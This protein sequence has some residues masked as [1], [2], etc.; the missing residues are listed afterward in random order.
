M[1]LCISIIYILC[2]RLRVYTFP[3]IVKVLTFAPYNFKSNAIMRA[4]ERYERAW[5]GQVLN[6]SAKI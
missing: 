5:N 6:R 1:F 2:K 3:F 4:T